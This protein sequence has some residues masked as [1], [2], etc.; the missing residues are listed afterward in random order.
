MS[1]CIIGIIALLLGLAFFVAVTVAKAK[2][3]WSFV[4]HNEE[5][6]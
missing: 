2:I 3:G 1:E 5:E 6:D 4:N